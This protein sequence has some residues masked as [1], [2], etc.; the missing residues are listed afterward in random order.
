MTALF[1]VTGLV[2]PAQDNARELVL[3]DQGLADELVKLAA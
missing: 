3:A 2:T 1:K